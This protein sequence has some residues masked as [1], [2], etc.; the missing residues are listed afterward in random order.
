MAIGPE[1]PDVA[2]IKVCIMHAHVSFLCINRMIPSSIVGVQQ[3][4]AMLHAKQRNFAAALQLEKEVLEIRMRSFGA[5]H[6]HTAHALMLVDRIE[7]DL[8]SLTH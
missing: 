1:H 6:P 7:R 5:E 3:T 8:S 4:L 2:N